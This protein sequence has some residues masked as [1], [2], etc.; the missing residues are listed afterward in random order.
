MA[1]LER[2]QAALDEAARAMAEAVREAFPVG[3]QVK[4]IGRGREKYKVSGY[5]AMD[6]HR[7]CY[8]HVSKRNTATDAMRYTMLRRVEPKEKP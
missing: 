2:A 5:G 6:A 8:V 4:I 3:T 1:N 7:C